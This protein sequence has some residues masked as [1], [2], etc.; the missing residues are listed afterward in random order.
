MEERHYYYMATLISPYQTKVE[1]SLPL[2][3]DTWI[4]AISWISTR[5]PEKYALYSIRIELIR[6]E[7]LCD[8]QETHKEEKNI[9][10]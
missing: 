10:E 9:A 2:D 5:I 8:N 6:S 1:I 4:S 7:N 3:I